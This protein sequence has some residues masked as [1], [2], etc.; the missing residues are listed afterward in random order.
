MVFNH[1]MSAQNHKITREDA[2]FIIDYLIRALHEAELARDADFVVYGS[3]FEKWREGLS[4]V[5]G[6]FYFS[7]LP[8]L[9]PSLRPKIQAFQ[10][11]IALLYDQLPFLKQGHFLYDIFILDSF[12]GKDGRFMIFD[13]DWINAFWKDTAYEFMHGSRF[14]NNLNPVLLRNQNEFELACGL[15]KLRN[16][17]FF[18]IPRLPSEMSLFCTK[19]ILKSLKVL[20]RV[21]TL[22]IGKPMAKNPQALTDY[23]KGID[24]NPLFNLWEKTSNHESLECYLKEWHEPGSKTFI[25]CLECFELTLTELVK[26]FPMRSSR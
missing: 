22:I 26:N 12:H 1:I 16:Y 10:S 2:R 24:F 20:P 6:I 4:D 21:S 8:I 15:H 18:E 11:K 13:K 19:D 17:L 25:D 5:D 3:Y 9:N 7:D 23:F 14:I